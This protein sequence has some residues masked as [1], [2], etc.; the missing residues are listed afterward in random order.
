MG[1]KIGKYD[2]GK[3]NNITDVAGV[4]V[5]HST[6]IKGDSAIENLEG[7]ARTGVTMIVPGD[8]IYEAPMYT[9]VFSLN[10]NG[11]LTG[12]HGLKRQDY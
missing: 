9:G 2:T 8:D 4:K 5:G 6:V 7:V 1:I 12:I 10:G 3:W 11:E